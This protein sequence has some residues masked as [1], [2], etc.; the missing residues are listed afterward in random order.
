MSSPSQGA[1]GADA[2]PDYASAMRHFRKV[3]A[4]AW[5]EPTPE[6]RLA[7]HRLDFFCGHIDPLPGL[8]DYIPVETVMRHYTSLHPVAAHDTAQDFSIALITYLA[9]CRAEIRE[10]PLG[11]AFRGASVALTFD[12]AR[13]ELNCARFAQDDQ[14]LSYE[15]RYEMPRNMSR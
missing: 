1:V 10:T 13:H 14:Q 4:D 2:R 5:R 6:N 15:K 12:R 3:V 9:L 8:R 11:T 7:K